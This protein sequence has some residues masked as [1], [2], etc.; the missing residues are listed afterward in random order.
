MEED[1]RAYIDYLHKAVGVRLD[2]YILWFEVSMY[3]MQ[4]MQS[5]KRS[6]YL[7][8]NHLQ[9]SKREEL[10]FWPIGLIQILLEELSE[11]HEMLA[12]VEVIIHIDETSL[13]GIAVGLDISQQF[14]LI[15]CLV[16]VIFVV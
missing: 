14:D 16:H 15:Q 1:T 11:Y 5:S 9:L 3:D 2:E 13:I 6:E 10:R 4:F 8:R 7:L 12:M